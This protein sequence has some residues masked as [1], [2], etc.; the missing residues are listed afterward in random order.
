MF[1]LP[2]T[3]FGK[4]KFINDFLNIEDRKFTLSYKLN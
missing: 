4:T 2:Q 3:L 1:H